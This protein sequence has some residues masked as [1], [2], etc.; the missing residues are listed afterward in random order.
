M[1]L[2]FT[3][4]QEEAEDLTQEIFLRLYRN[5]RKYRGDVPLS[6]WA[7]RLS[8]NLCID[9]YRRARR[10]GRWT[11]LPEAVL[12]DLPATSNPEAETARREKLQVVYSALA[13][14]PEELSEVVVVRD[15]QGWTFE[16][17]AA[18]LGIPMGTLKSRL[19]RARLRLTEAVRA[20]TPVGGE[21]LGC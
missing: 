12:A 17:S 9:N 4:R 6:A 13:L 11:R 5:L 7:L 8:R 19:H 14:L 20:Q 15:L 18:Y 10:E 1:A 16:E 2:Q 21:A 3:G